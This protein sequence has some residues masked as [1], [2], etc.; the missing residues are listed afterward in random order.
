M[1][2]VV[3]IY[4]IRMCRGRKGVDERE[5]QTDKPQAIALYVAYIHHSHQTA[6]PRTLV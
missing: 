3:L 2:V 1:Y 4:N 5:V 6:T